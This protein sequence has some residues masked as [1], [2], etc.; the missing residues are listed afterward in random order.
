MTRR[1]ITLAKALA[2][3]L[4]QIQQPIVSSFQ[5]GCL[6]FNA[7][8]A[9]QVAGEDLGLKKIVP[10]KTQYLRALHELTSNGILSSVPGL[11][12]RFFKV[13]GKSDATPDEL[14]CSVDPFCYISHLSAMEYH[15]ITDRLPRTIFVSSPPPAAWKTYA[16]E[17]MARELGSQ[18]EQYLELGFPQLFRSH[19]KKIS[20]KIIEYKSSSHLGAFKNV[21]GSS[22]RVST[23]G[24][25]FLDMVRDPNLCGG[26]QHVIDVYKEYAKPYLRLIVDEVDMHGNGIEKARAGYLLESQANISDARIDAW[27]TTVQRGGSRKLDATAEYSPFFSERWALSLNVPSINSNAD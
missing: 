4:A 3:E 21:Q 1:K 20:G 25:T 13:I 7:Y 23:I 27:Q 16:T 12:E 14:I 26:I 6:I 19:P 8:Q 10:N 2:L 9:N 18:L 5:L 17:F 22:L 15:G 24:R 11:S